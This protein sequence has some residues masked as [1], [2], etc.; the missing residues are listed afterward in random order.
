MSQLWTSQKP[1]KYILYRGH[2]CIPEV[3]VDRTKGLRQLGQRPGDSG[4]R[5]SVASTWFCGISFLSTGHAGRMSNGLSSK[6]KE[7]HWISSAS[8]GALRPAW[9]P[10]CPGNTGQRR[11]SSIKSRKMT[12]T[13]I[14]KASEFIAVHFHIAFTMEI[15]IVQIFIVDFVALERSQSFLLSFAIIYEDLYYSTY[16][17]NSNK[18]SYIQKRFHNAF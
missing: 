13:N 1:L 16:F 11:P 17:K 6:P 7:Y 12:Y 8:F 2:I 15:L 4:L 18:Q 9:S 3:K 10:L 14:L 5:A